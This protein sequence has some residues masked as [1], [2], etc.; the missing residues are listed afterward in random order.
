MLTEDLGLF[1][2]LE[3]PGAAFQL[4]MTPSGSIM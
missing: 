1:I 4:V 2:P 3:T